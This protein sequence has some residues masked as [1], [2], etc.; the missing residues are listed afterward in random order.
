[1]KGLVSVASYYPSH[2]I[3]MQLI[4]GSAVSEDGPLW[5]VLLSLLCCCHVEI[6]EDAAWQS[7]Q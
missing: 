2:E 1:M 7:E 3:M 6:Q 5:S 4:G